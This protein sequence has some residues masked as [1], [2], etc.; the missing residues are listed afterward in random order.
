MGE[1]RSFDIDL[2]RSFL[3]IAGGVSFTRTAERVGRTQ[4]AVTLQIKRLEA[5]VGHRL[6]ARGRGLGVKLTPKGEHLAALARELVSLNDNIIGS[7]KSEHPAPALPFEGPTAGKPS[8]AV[9]PFEDMSDDASHRYFVTGIVDDLI[10]RLSRIRWLVVIACNSC[11][12]YGGKSVDIREIGKALGV[13]YVLRGG[14]RKAGGRVRIT[15]QLLE[16]DTR[17]ALWADTFDGSLEDVFDLQDRIADQIVGLL[18]PRLQRSEIERATQTHPKSLDAY[19]LYLRALALVSAH[20]PHEAE[21]A[22]PLLDKALHLD[23]DYALAHALAGWCHEWRFTRSGFQESERQR[24]F[25]HARAAAAGDDPTAAAIAGFS[26]VFLTQDRGE[27]LEAIGRGVALNPCSA[28]AMHLNAHAHSI[29]GQHAAAAIFAGLALHLSPNDPL[30]FEAHMALGEGAI[31]ES[32]Y[33]DAA[34]CFARAA[35]T[36]PKF[37]T[38]YFFRAMSQARAGHADRAGLSLRLGKSSNR[39]FERACCSRLEWRPRSRT[40]SPKA[41]VSFRWAISAASPTIAKSVIALSMSLN[42][43][44]PGPP[45]SARW[46]PREGGV[47]PRRSVGARSRS[48]LRLA[49]EEH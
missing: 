22:L 6:L 27:S 36:N 37:S 17:A 24:A 19:S 35:R 8:I 31:R 2:L 1:P 20:M 41:R 46:S 4:A 11:S 16:A 18:E 10:S 45:V 49:G 3:L 21:Q 33:E 25:Q 42:R 12:S 43:L 40:N 15:A 47:G 7:L 30:A 26:M 5:M 9:L 23:P 39:I 14:L 32:R 48:G 28:T 34:E 29:A 38:A 44:G 13:R